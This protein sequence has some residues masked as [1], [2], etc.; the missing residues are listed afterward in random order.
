MV[1]VSRQAIALLT[2]AMDQYKDDRLKDTGP[3]MLREFCD[4]ANH[5]RKLSEQDIKSFCLRWKMSPKRLV[6]DGRARPHGAYPKRWLV[7]LVILHYQLPILHLLLHM[8]DD[9]LTDHKQVEVFNSQSHLF[10]AYNLCI[11]VWSH[12]RG[13]MYFYMLCKLSFTS[14]FR[15]C[16]LNICLRW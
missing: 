11:V 3:Q 12:R 5:L 15:N 9:F 10:Q 1:S 8:Y 7:S 6:H 4:V 14:A 2:S 13:Q 16:L